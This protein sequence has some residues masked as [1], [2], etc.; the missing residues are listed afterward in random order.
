LRARLNVLLTAYNGEKYIR[1]QIES[2]LNQSQKPNKIFINI[3]QSEDK[4]VSVVQD[5]AKKNP[6]IK[7]LNSDKRFGSAAANFINLII[8]ADLSDVDYIALADQDDLWKEDKL[9]KAIQKL[10]QGYD[11]YSSNVEAFWANGKRKVLVKN[12]PQQKFDHL[13]ESAGPGCT[14]VLNKKLALKLQQFLKIGHFSQLHNYH[15]WLIFAF[16]RSHDFKWHIDS[17]TSVEYRQHD[18]NVFGANV[19]IKA[20]VSRSRRVLSGEGVDFAF[21]LMKELKVQDPFIQSLFPVSRINL[22]RLALRAIQC[23]RRA[24]DQIY[25]FF[26]CILLTIIFPKKLRII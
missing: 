13:F 22:L 5:L 1:Q 2:I 16:A 23:R 8:D 3:D 11:G 17:Y 9:E 21:R 24:R 7:I 25:F 15:D 6:I 12:Q 20:F 10:K 14:F 19:G 4:T 26:A 18:T